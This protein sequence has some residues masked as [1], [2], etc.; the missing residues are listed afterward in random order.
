[1]IEILRFPDPRGDPLTVVSAAGA[2]VNS[3]AGAAVVSAAGA[4]VDSAVAPFGCLAPLPQRFGS[5]DNGTLTS[6]SDFDCFVIV[7]PRLQHPTKFG[8]E[9]GKDLLA[10]LPGLVEGVR[11]SWGKSTLS[12]KVLL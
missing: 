3:A 10:T 8:E 5:C 7:D 1:M 4:A 6:D 11:M 12:G 2:A 9:F